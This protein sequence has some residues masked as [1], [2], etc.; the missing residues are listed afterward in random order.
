MTGDRFEVAVVG[1]GPVGLA[2]ALAFAQ[3][4][5]ATCLVGPEPERRDGRTAALLGPS[6]DLLRDIEIWPAL[7]E[8]SGPLRVLRIVDDTGSLFRPPPVSF[9]ADEIGL[10][11]FGWN[12]ENA[13][14]AGILADAA[15]A[16]SGLTW[17]TALVGGFE[18][19]DLAHL[20]CLDGSRIAAS[21][22]VA[23]DGRHS[24]V[25]EAAGITTSERSYRQSAFTTILRHERPHGDASTE[26]HT[27]SGPFT[28][29]P[30]PGRRSS[31]VWVT[32]PRHAERL[33]GASDADLAFAVEAAAASLLGT[34]TVAGP[35]GTVPL[36]TMSVSGYVGPRLALAGEAAH[37]LP[38]IGA[39]GLN[40]GLADVAALVRMLTAS[41]AEGIDVG[42]EAGLARYARERQNDVRLRSVAVD[43]LNRSLLAGFA[44]ID[45]ARGIG[46]G[47]LGGIGPLRRA[48]MRAGLAGGVSH[49]GV[50]RG[51]ASAGSSRS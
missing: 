1:A 8:A 43:G 15:R 34:M 3:A 42:A 7:A 40:L 49:P 6:V 2:A 10:E 35:R 22:V 11:A 50:S 44:P 12:V 23:A 9:R 47:L 41:R 4:G 48:V 25:R 32:L 30:L 13:R 27:G 33:M 36:S 18:T 46:L 16:Q 5:L 19:D 14:L 17:S 38:P 24:R 26:F 21:L 39:Q 28:L 37:V 45:A 31:L 51:R 29:V 20:S